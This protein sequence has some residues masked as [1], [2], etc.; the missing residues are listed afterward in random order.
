VS[1]WRT[2]SAPAKLNLALVVGPLRPDGKHEVV[3][4][5]EKLELV[6]TVSVRPAGSTNVE[7]F[8]GDTLVRSA[9]DAVSAA[10]GGDIRFEARLVKRIPVAAGLGGGSSDAATALFLA[11]GLLPKPLAGA[12]LERLAGSLGADVPFFLH[13]G[14]QLGTGDGT[15]LE[16]LELPRDYTVVLAQPHG[17]TKRSTADVY[18]AFDA[19]SGAAGFEE[20]RGH[21]LEVL[22]QV[23]ST[24]DLA[25]LPPNDLASSPLA[26]ELVVL[27]AVRA[28]ATG[29]GPT[30]FG[31]FADPLDAVRA[32]EA[33]ADRAAT[34]VTKPA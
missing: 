31:L 26:A 24:G 14:P 10:G 16:P 33:V 23:R 20:R 3:T 32:A 4:V 11:N 27:G 12:E 25:R 5:L 15:A 17:E 7:G 18:A 22:E 19:R 21:L 6:D 13:H 28:D 2:A 29:A 8:A 1:G 34:W 9:L 30:V